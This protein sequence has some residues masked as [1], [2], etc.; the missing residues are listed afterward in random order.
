MS[1][2]LGSSGRITHSRVNTKVAHPAVDANRLGARQDD[3]PSKDSSETP[4]GVFRLTHTKQ[5][6]GK[7]CFSVHIAQAWTLNTC[8]FLRDQRITLHNSHL[9]QRQVRR[10]WSPPHTRQ[11]LLDVNGDVTINSNRGGSHMDVA[12]QV[13]MPIRNLRQRSDGR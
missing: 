4:E 10:R 2:G 9:P 13:C 6:A 7:V 3:M 5:H 1:I 11:M 8:D 12:S